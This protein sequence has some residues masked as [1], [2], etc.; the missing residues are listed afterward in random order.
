M[1]DYRKE[2]EEARERWADDPIEIMAAL[3]QKIFD[4]SNLLAEK[5]KIIKELSQ[6][7]TD[8]EAE[9]IKHGWWIYDEYCIPHCSNCGT[10]NNTVYRNYCPNCGTIM[11]EVEE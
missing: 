8:I 11:G 4:L 6:I 1:N 5:D 9:P 2:V 10:I 3:K 7:R